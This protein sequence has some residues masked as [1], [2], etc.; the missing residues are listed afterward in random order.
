MHFLYPKFLFAL[1]A[2][3]IPIIIH[4]F[5]F[6]RYKTI[7]FSNVK[8]LKNVKQETQSKSQLKHILVLISRILIISAIVIAFAQPYI[9]VNNKIISNKKQTVSLYVDN[10]FSMNAENRYGNLF[11]ISKNK[12]RQIADA[13]KPNTQF[14]LQ[15]NDFDSKHQHLVNKEQLIDFLSDI[16]ISSNTKKLSQIL[17][18]QNDFLSSSNQKKTVFIIS[19][20]QKKFANFNQIKN[21][22]SVNVFLVPQTAESVNN[23]FIDSCWFETPSHKLN[24]AEKIFV[25]IINN[26]N[27]SYQNIPVKLL[28]NDTI[29]ALSSFNIDKNSIKIIPLSY[30][31]TQSG[32]HKG[33][34]EITD[35]PIT[36]D[37][38]FY[39]SYIIYN[40]VKILSI[41]QNSA[42][43]FV[44]ALFKKDNNIE[45]VNSQVNNLN[46]SQIPSYQLIIFNS[47]KTLSSGLSQALINYVQNGGTLL[48]L[49]N[50]DGDIT[51]YN[52][53]LSAIKSNRITEIDSQ[54][55]KINYINY[56]NELYK[57][58]F[59]KID[60]NVDLPIVFKHFVF[61]NNTYSNN[62][63]ILT[64]NKQ[65]I[66]SVLPF[67][68]GKIYIFSF[69]L[70]EAYSNFVKN[71]LFIPTL[72]NIALFSQSFND[73]YYTIGKNKTIELNK[74]Y[75]TNNNVFHIIN[76]KLNFDFIPQH[77]IID[78]KIIL[79]LNNNIEKAENYIVKNNNKTITGISFNY[80][81]EESDLNYYSKNEL[82]DLLKKNNLKNFSILN[83][84]NK[85]F[86]HNLSQINKGKQLWKI[87]IVIALI[88]LGIETL[89]L[90]FF[91]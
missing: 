68:K 88:L 26:S 17:S 14:L 58:V 46:F 2:I 91:K 16:K 27:E 71:S 23:L 67:K 34:V 65:T 35:Y 75:S 57:N 40:K 77:K 43:K 81:R 63:N 31:N 85:F 1:I 18:R 3:A 21:D 73:I 78:S 52:K 33:R 51:T 22:T 5:N 7:Y 79:F 48:F 89:L 20:F 80:N 50:F 6:K 59:E 13:F 45:L 84:E 64:A 90:R 44:N 53:F 87:F 69:P 66:L 29:K 61:D 10:S 19:D 36:Y 38:I 41:N 42:N 62:E 76:K 49:P 70:S 28:I 47:V 24:K 54:K 39:F 32:I 4:L 60:K 82:I 74:K 15:T 11:D 55:I 56:K 30:S 83:S 86:A 9:P 37:N 12:A 25:K 8:F 72:Y